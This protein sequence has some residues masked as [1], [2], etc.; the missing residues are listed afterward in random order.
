MSSNKVT[1]QQEAV[2]QIDRSTQ[3]SS[4]DIPLSQMN[5]KQDDI[6]GA[7]KGFIAK[8]RGGP[9]PDSSSVATSTDIP[10]GPTP[11]AGTASTKPSGG[12]VS[13]AAVA[14]ALTPEA[15]KT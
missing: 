13:S 10:K 14:S 4:V 15:R 8:K 9:S 12:G 5:S 6:G 1:K 3:S 11:T 7:L 2:T